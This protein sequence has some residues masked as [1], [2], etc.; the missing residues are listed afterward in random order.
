MTLIKASQLD[1]I[2]RLR[3]FVGDRVSVADDRGEAGE[4]G[5]GEGGLRF[6]EHESG[7]VGHPM[8]SVP[9]IYIIIIVMGEP[10]VERRRARADRQTDWLPLRS[11]RRAATG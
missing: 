2:R 10:G 6:V 11:D 3:V 8:S 5:W 7:S 1:Q 9:S 4:Q